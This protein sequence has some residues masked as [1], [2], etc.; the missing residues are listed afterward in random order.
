V[1]QYSIYLDRREAQLCVAL[2]GGPP[3][4]EFCLEDGKGYSKASCPCLKL[5]EQL[6]KTAD[7]S[8]IGKRGAGQGEVVHVAEHQA[9]GDYE[10]AVGEINK[11]EQWKDG[12]ALNGPNI[13][14]GWGALCPLEDQRAAGLAHER[15]HP[16]DQVVGDRAF[17]E[18]A[19]QS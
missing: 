10:V 4:N 13:N 18:D 7:V 12:G 17:P 9:S 6:L 8:T 14:G 11:E 1:K 5:C 16:G 15:S 3:L 19:G 2:A